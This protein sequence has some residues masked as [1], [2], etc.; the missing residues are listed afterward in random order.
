MTQAQGR[1][2]HVTSAFIPPEFFFLP[3]LSLNLSR[4]HLCELPS[5]DLDE[6]RQLLKVGWVA[7]VVLVQLH[8]FLIGTLVLVLAE[9]RIFF[10]L[11][12]SSSSKCVEH[13]F[14]TGLFSFSL[15]LFFFFSLFLS[16]ILTLSFPLFI[17]L[18]VSHTIPSFPFSG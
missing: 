18:F 15:S 9:I 10:N 7:L 4:P 5:I 16:F 6:H 13:A 1:T 14:F 11:F 3:L 8:N 12:F 17:S 2:Y